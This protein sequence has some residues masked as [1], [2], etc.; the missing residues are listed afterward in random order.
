[1]REMFIKVILLASAFLFFITGTS[2]SSDSATS[3]QEKECD[4]SDFA[5]GADVSWLT[6]MEH[7]GVKFYNQQGKRI[8]LFTF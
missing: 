5:K 8:K 6:E 7:D 2:C 3:E 1:M 4:M